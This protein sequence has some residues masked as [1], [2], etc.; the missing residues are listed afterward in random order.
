[1]ITVRGLVER[2]ETTLKMLVFDDLETIRSVQLYGTD[3]VYV[4]KATE[5]LCAEYGVAPHRPQLRLPGAQGDPQGRRW[6][7]AVEARAAR[8]DPGGGGR[9]RRRRTTSRSP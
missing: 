5:I 4:G 9:R 6:R 2:D 3:P 1:M 7:A 8:R